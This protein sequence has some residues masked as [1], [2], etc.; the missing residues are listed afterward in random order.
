VRIGIQKELTM[1]KKV[2]KQLKEDEFV[3]TVQKI[4]DFAKDRSRELII[5]GV[6]VC[7]IIIVVFVVRAIQAQAEKRESR[8]LGDILAVTSQ[9]PDSPEK[10]SDLEAL[11]GDGKFSRVAYLELA[12]YWV[13][14]GDSEKAKSSLAEITEEWK[15]LTYYQ[16]RDLM[17]QIY[18]NSKEFDRA[19]EV[20]KEIEKENPKEYPMDVILFR[21]AEVYEKKGD[22]AAALELYTK[23][24]DEFSQTYYGA[25]ASRKVRELEEK[26]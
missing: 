1:K 5:A 19:L 9:L 2:K 13:E 3:H 23:V 17:G 22:T 12:S 24:Q 16:A 25:D 15:D 6:A 4:I 8:I 18:L 10:V 20:Y 11:A 7:L 14:Q 26:K 21:Q